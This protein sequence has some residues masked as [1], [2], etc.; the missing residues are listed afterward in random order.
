M[1]L[2]KLWKIKNTSRIFLAAPSAQ[3]E[4]S[5]L[6]N[7]IWIKKIGFGSKKLNFDGKCTLPATNRGK[8]TTRRKYITCMKLNFN[9]YKDSVEFISN[10]N[11]CSMRPGTLFTLTLI[12]CPS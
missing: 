11:Y 2:P 8:G 5:K 4:T 3:A 12:K 7:W 9:F 6:V 10:H 1:K